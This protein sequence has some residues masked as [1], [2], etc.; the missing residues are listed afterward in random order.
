VLKDGAVSVLKDGMRE[1]HAL[2]GAA[3]GSPDRKLDRLQV[4]AGGRDVW[5]ITRSGSRCAIDRYL[6]QAPARP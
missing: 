1:T 4:T 6:W 3:A 2:A 5:A